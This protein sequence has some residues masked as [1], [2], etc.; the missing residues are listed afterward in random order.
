MNTVTKQYIYKDKIVFLLNTD[1][2]YIFKITSKTQKGL[3]YYSLP[4]NDLSNCESDSY[5]VCKSIK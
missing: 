5:K 3:E 1:K 4:Y 2:G